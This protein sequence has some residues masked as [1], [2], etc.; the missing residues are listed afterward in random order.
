[1]LSVISYAAILLLCAA[2]PLRA[3][4]N[5]YRADATRGGFT[6]EPLPDRLYL[7]WVFHPAQPPAPAWRGVDTRMPFD[8]AFHTVAAGGKLFFGS[9]ADCKLYALDA[10]SGRELWSFF[11]GSPVRFAP[12]VRGE[13]LYA[14]S[15]DGFLYCLSAADGRLQWKVRGGPGGGLVL[16]ND[17]L[18]SR[19]PAR[20]GLAV[21]GDTVFFAAGIWPSEGIY[22]HAV[23][24]RTGGSIWVND[25]SG[26]MVMDKPHGGARARSGVSAQGYLA[27]DGTT[28]LVPTGRSVP[29]AFDSHTGR[30]RYFHQQNNRSLGGSR[31]M[32]TAGFFLADAGN[33]RSTELRAGPHKALFRASD[34]SRAAVN[35]LHATA[36]AC[37]PDGWLYCSDRSGFHG[38][39][40]DSAFEQRPVRDRNGQASPRDYLKAP[41]LNIPT[42]GFT[43]GVSLIVAAD[44]AVMG[45]ADGRV[46]VVDLTGERL[47]WSAAIEGRPL[48]LAACGGKLFVSS[49]NG[50]IYCFGGEAT[51]GPEHIH[52]PR[53]N[54]PYGDN[55]LYERAAREI[56]E[57][58]GVTEGYCVDLGCGD[59]RLAFELARL[60][61]LRIYAVD[62]D[63]ER[64][65]RARRL[66][67]SAGLY[68]TRVTVHLADPQATDYPDYFANLVVSAQSVEQEAQAFA[69]AEARRLM[70]P[71]GG[72][73]CVG[74]PERMEL[75]RREAL[76]GADPEWSHLYHDPANTLSSSDSLVGG[77]LSILWYRDSDQLMPSRHGRGVG[78]LFSRGLLFV[79]G[80]DELRAVDA[81]NGR[82]VWS[83]PLMD[84]MKAYDQ[85][86]LVG[87][88][89][90][91][92]NICLEGDRLYLRSPGNPTDGDFAGKSCLVLDVASGRKIAEYTIP[93][94]D[95]NSEGSKFW[96][97]LAVQ[98]GILYGSVANTDHV[99]EYSY[100]E[101]DMNKLF[102]ESKRFFAL[103]ASTGERLWSFTPEH[104]IRHNAIAIGGGAVYLIDRPLAVSDAVVRN[105]HRAGRTLTQSD[106]H[107]EGTLL[108]LDARTGSELWRSQE[109]VFGT[110]LVLS[111]ERDVLLMSYQDTRFKQDSEFGG[112]MRAFRASCGVRLW[113]V[114]IEKKK[115]YN[116]SSRPLVIG[117]TVY[118]EPGAWELETG[119]RL[120]FSMARSYACGIITGCPEMLV[121]RSAT[122]GYLD[123]T[124][125][126]STE[127]Y[128]GIRPGCW[129]N[130]LPVGGLVLMPDATARCDCSYLIKANIA[131]APTR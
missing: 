66:L 131:L 67:D 62:P 69:G 97:Y 109:K 76:A 35:E 6:A 3:D 4:W 84:L 30:F 81:Y 117:N 128:G 64:V 39:D 122:M 32:A 8:Y 114:G 20:G 19:W 129:I 94:D 16:G 118:L 104:S 92:G 56:I 24:A 23:E 1:M 54:E 78:P 96:G 123:L 51:S 74:R 46:A 121:F 80:I 27:L 34:G 55:S 63:P 89:A 59:G 13:R 130:A 91:Q 83:Y 103:E 82:P 125:G 106:L 42:P 65:A 87:A 72:M 52:Q 98:D 45:T 100:R 120:D 86:H 14:L 10:E 5:Q 70:R 112:K 93:G 108:A 68:G 58:T 85:E 60:T 18:V 50:S 73:S 111:S 101:S 113:D 47:A 43:G 57:R 33:S 115:G 79:Q 90:T 21:V 53:V 107:P 37:T 61:N 25:S 31:V 22:L 116:Y 36:V 2:C 126:G 26:G 40:L 119:M 11:T 99:L 28:L 48:G 17:H 105:P 12:A 15:D 29:A 110:L 49:D 77:K 95:E 41:S 9:S 44:K 75:E 71:W 127:N 124:R 7:Q 102:S 38:W 88:A